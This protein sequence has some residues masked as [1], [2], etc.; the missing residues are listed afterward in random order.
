MEEET[1]QSTGFK[2][3]GSLTTAAT[4]ERF[5]VLKRNAARATSYGLD[6]DIFT[7]QQCADMMAHNG[8]PSLI[9]TEDLQGGLWLPGD[10]SGSPTDLTMSF[11]AGAKKMGVS[12]VE[13][14]G[15]TGF[16][17]A[18]VSGVGVDRLSAVETDAGTVECEY[19]V[20][21]AGQWSRQVAALAG[22]NVP[23]HSCE[24]FYCTTQSMEGVHPNLPV[25][26]DNDSFTYFRQVL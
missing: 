6:A 12:I 4:P 9:R 1:G 26:R 18:S 15:V 21:C 17:T 24:H 23:L 22:V 8:G 5:E 13:G 2:Q 14:V 20:L 11:A 10:G 25:Y 7:P 19:V 3:C 16:Q